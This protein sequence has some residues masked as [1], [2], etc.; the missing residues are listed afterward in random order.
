MS[1]VRV[2][3]LVSRFI[4]SSSEPESSLSVSTS[5]SLNKRSTGRRNNVLTNV[6]VWTSGSSLPPAPF[7]GSK[8]AMASRSRGSSRR[9][10]T[11]TV[12]AADTHALQTRPISVMR[13]ILVWTY[14]SWSKRGSKIIS[15]SSCGT[16]A[17]ALPGSFESGDG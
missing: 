12:S 2:E 5:S 8:Y 11:A 16:R 4:S 17:Q 9:T 7:A 3:I 6:H 10:S 13:R 1:A 15:S 14:S